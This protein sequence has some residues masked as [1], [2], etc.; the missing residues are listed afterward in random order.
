MRI[1]GYLFLLVIILLGVTFSTLNAEAVTVNYYVGRSTLPLSLLLVIT[2]SL[3]CVLGMLVGAW[4]LMK[5]K[6]QNYRLK[7][8]LTLAEKEVTNLRVIPLRDQ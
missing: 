1:I 4:L 8:Q 7:H 3:G 6:V 2:F 5:T